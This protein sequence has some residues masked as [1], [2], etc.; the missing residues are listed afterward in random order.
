MPIGR[1]H[2]FAGQPAYGRPLPRSILKAIGGL[3]QGGQHAW[4]LIRTVWVWSAFERFAAVGHGVRLGPNAWCY[5]RGKR[6]SIRIGDRSICRGV[7][8]CESFGSGEII[9]HEDVYLGDDC[10][11]SSAVRVEIHRNSLLAHGVQVF[12]ND[13]HPLKAGERAADY[14]ALLHGS[15]TRGEIA[16]KPITIGPNAWIGAQ[17]ILLKGVTVGEDSLIAAGSVVTKDIPSHRFA[18]GNPAKVRGT[19]NE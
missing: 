2:A 8:R 1:A 17:T 6:S 16:S 11:I 19:V 5:N 13:A 14:D 12:D 4:G 10:L 7:L 18:A 3:V 15:R 9:I